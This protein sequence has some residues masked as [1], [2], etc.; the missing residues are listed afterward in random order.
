MHGEERSES[1]KKTM[2]WFDL[3]RPTHKSAAEA[4]KSGRL[5]E[6][7]SFVTMIAALLSFT[8]CSDGTALTEHY[9]TSYEPA[10]A[11][12]A[13]N[14]LPVLVL[15]NPYNISP[16]DLHKSVVSALQVES[17]Y[18]SVHFSER[19]QDGA[20]PFRMVVVFAP[21]PQASAA[22]LCSNPGAVRPMTVFP[23]TEE[24]PILASFCHDGRLL[25]QV[26]GVIGAGAAPN[27]GRFREG[28]GQVA[29]AL[30]PGIDESLKPR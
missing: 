12:L 28:L 18:L 17:D 29:I 16:T 20:S 19:L 4:S 1:G 23:G 9:A 24:V 22:D 5:S 21:P 7:V 25:S 8:A 26:S 27:S 6:R 30:F 13:G 10:D 15:G 11:I 3:S 14:D 2:V